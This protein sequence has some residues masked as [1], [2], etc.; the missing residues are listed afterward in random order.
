MLGLVQGV[1]EF[2]PVSSSAHLIIV[3]YIFG[4]ARHSDEFDIALHLGSLIAIAVYFWPEIIRLLKAGFSRAQSKDKRLFWY[5]IIATVPA[6]LIGYLFEDYVDEKLRSA[7]LLIAIAL[8]VMGIVLVWADKI[9]AKKRDEYTLSWLESLVIGCSQAIALLPGVSRSGSTMTAGLFFGL[10]R[11]AAAKFSFLMSIPIIL[12][13]GL[14]K[15]RHLHATD[16]NGP[17]LVGVVVAAIVG[18]FSIRWLLNY[19]KKS[20]FSVF[21]WYRIGLAALVLIVYIFRR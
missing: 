2:L 1:G 13:A 20:S 3:P 14:L 16:I 10:N 5:V 19:L 7:I 4:W 15:L 12:G 6:G 8:A 21:A 18:Y 17:F 9:S 11:E